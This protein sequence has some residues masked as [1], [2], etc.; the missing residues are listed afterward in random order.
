MTSLAMGPSQVITLFAI[1]FFFC[2]SQTHVQ[3]Y[4]Y[5]YLGINQIGV[6]NELS[7]IWDNSKDFGNNPVCD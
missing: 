2:I 1:V 6:H 5:L 3:N 7:L 4:Y